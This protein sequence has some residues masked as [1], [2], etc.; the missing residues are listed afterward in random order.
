ML[1]AS[2]TLIGVGLA[3][4]VFGLSPDGWSDL[5]TGG[6]QG[7][8]LPLRMPPPQA[9]MAV[10]GALYLSGIILLAGALLR[11]AAVTH[12][13]A[14]ARQRADLESLQSAVLMAVERL[15]LD[16]REAY[17]QKQRVSSEFRDLAEEFERA[18]VAGR[19]VD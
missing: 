18:N 4:L 16:H 19:G 1:T 12:L 3:G 15:E 6:L 10:S 17:R 9:I 7:A 13:Q 5:V 2:I 11:R 8:P 14:L